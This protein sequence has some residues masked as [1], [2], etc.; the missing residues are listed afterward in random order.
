MSDLIN[1]QQAIDVLEEQLHYLFMLNKAENPTAESKWDGINWARNTIA[2][3]PS[4]EPKVG[5]WERKPYKRQGH[6]E[7]VIEGCSWRCSNC[8]GCTEAKRTR[9]EFLSQLWSKDGK[10]R[11]MSILIKDIDLPKDNKPLNLEI[12]SDGHI[13]IN[14]GPEYERKDNVAIQIDRPHGRLGDLD[15][16]LEESLKE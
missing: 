15:V 13:W 11:V 16:L 5:K 3:L 4:A 2:E 6:E 1:R 14:W 12:Y 10:E 8:G 7:V 9:Y